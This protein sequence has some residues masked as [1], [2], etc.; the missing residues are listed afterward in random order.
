[1]LDRWLGTAFG[2]YLQVHARAR[3]GHGLERIGER[4]PQVPLPEALPLPAR[5]GVSK[6]A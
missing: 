1:V 6:A 4:L 5:E 2:D 3:E